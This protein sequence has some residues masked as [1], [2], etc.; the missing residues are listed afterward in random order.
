[1]PGSSAIVSPTST[2][3]VQSPWF[4]FPRDRAASGSPGRIPARA[5]SGPS[6]TPPGGDKAG[7]DSLPA[8]GGK[9]ASAKVRQGDRKP[10]A[11]VPARAGSFEKDT[12][13][14]LDTCG[15]VASL[16]DPAPGGSLLGRGRSAPAE[17]S[18]APEAA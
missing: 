8:P 7:E 13:N 6:V 10:G 16:A 15:Q 5:S 11:G 14:A 9:E 17:E 18:F 12:A 1:M 4:P 2:G 3:A